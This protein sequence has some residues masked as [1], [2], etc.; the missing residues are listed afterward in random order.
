M[1]INDMQGKVRKG[2]EEFSHPASLSK[3]LQMG[4]EVW[5]ND[6]YWLVMPFKL[7]DS[8]VRLTYAREDTTQTGQKADVLDLQFKNV[9]VT[10]NNR[11]EVYVDQEDHLVTQ[12]N[13]FTNATDSMPRFSTPWDGYKQHGKIMLSSGRGNYQLSEIAVRESMADAAFESFDWTE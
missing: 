4:K 8:G 12:W 7:K 3:S 11:Y 6:S 9:G 1:N 5:I 13:F 2:G 10:P